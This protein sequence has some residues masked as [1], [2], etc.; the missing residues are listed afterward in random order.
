MK[1]TVNF[2]QVVSVSVTV[3]IDG[4][5]EEDLVEAVIERAFEEAPSGVCAQ[6]SGWGQDWGR[7]D[8]GELVVDSVMNESGETIH[9][10]DEE[11]RLV[12][13]SGS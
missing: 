1:Y 12:R 5:R 9:T 10:E 7:D 4:D 2:Q 13:R 8:D 6:C 11:W 3:D